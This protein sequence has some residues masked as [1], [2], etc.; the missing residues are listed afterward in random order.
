M[1][2]RKCVFSRL[3]KY[4]IIWGFI[5]VCTYVVCDT[6]CG[7]RLQNVNSSSIEQELSELL[8]KNKE[9]KAFV[10]NY[11]NRVQYL[12]QDI[13]LSKDFSEGKVPLLMQW[14]MRWGYENFGDSIIG[15]SGCGPTCLSMAYVYFTEDLGGNPR[16]MADFCEENGYYTSSGTSW[17]LWT[18]GVEELGLSG[19]ELS[20]DEKVMKKVLDNGS[21]IICSMRP[22]D[23]TTT[24]HYILIY[25]YDADGFWVNDPN[26]K[27][28]CEKGWSYNT[29]RG[30]IKN[31]WAVC[32]KL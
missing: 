17:D 29:L 9:A 32:T 19:R 7:V 16:E 21:L 22:G 8:E 13:D 12:G 1:R 31:L 4:I 30:Q 11:Q 26:R 23:F 24:G 27:S 28:N 5:C 25:G 10:D 20:L 6:E 3:C 2:K 15:L 18:K 14:D